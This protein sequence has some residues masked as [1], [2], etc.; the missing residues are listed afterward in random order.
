MQSAKKIWR[1]VFLVIP[2]LFAGNVFAAV[3]VD[4]YTPE[5]TA[6][7]AR[8]GFLRGE[9]QIRRADAKDWERATQNLPVVEGDE[10]TTDAGGRLEIQFNSRTYLRLSENSYLKIAVLKDEGIAVSLSQGSLNL[11]VLEFDRSQTYFEIDAPQTTVAVQKA[12]MYRVDAGDKRNME[13]RIAVTEAGEARI[14]SESSGFTLRSG[15]SAKVYLEGNFAGEWET[16]DAARYADDFDSWALERD[17]IIAKR[18]KDAYYDKYYDRDIYGA[19]DLN[20][21]GEW[22]YTRKY[23]YV[24]R[25]FRNSVAA[26]ADWS[27]YRYGHWRWIPPYG[28]TWVNDEPWGWATY[29]HGRWVYDD[30][31]WVW[32]PYGQIRYRRSWWS[33]ALTVVTWNGSLICWYPI[34]YESHNYNYN[35]HYSSRRRNNTTIINNNTTIINNNPPVVANPNQPPVVTS[36]PNPTNEQRTARLLTPG[37]QRIPPSGVIAVDASEFGR[38]T[39]GYRT[40]PLETARTVLA[41]TPEVIESPPLLPTYTDLNGRMSREIVA[42]APPVSRIETRTRIGAGERRNDGSLDE[43]LRKTRIYGNRPPIVANPVQPETTTQNSENGENRRDRRRTGAVERTETGSDGG[44]ET[45]RK[46]RV[47]YTPPGN[48]EPNRTEESKPI[49]RERQ[50]PARQRRD[51]SNADQSPPI[52]EQPVERPK[53]RREPPAESPRYEQSKPPRD[54]PRPDPPRREEPRNDPPPKREEPR[55]EPKQKSDPPEE[56]KSAAPLRGKDGRDD[57]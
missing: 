13:V 55:Q 32:T 2:L 11:R 35:R 34:P 47:P 5:V 49:E 8:I 6:R 24:W 38:R 15:R 12:G 27:P 17:A 42:S 44:T 46:Q 56:R 37:L 26:Y 53:E 48:S 22:I 54:E 40:A 29:H 16:G 10:I 30:G 3:T 52:Y 33:P 18:L 36:A 28:W 39:G 31:A 20:D 9:A 21:Y 4:D 25:P 45:N 57:D 14:Y 43:E 1:A 7:V 19:E 41:K 51:D 23:G 50:K